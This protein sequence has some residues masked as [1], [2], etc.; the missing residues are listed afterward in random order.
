MHFAQNLPGREKHVDNVCLKSRQGIC[1]VVLEARGNKWNFKVDTK[2][3]TAYRIQLQSQAS[4]YTPFKI[5]TAC[6]MLFI[7]FPR[8]E[9]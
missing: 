9:K 3:Q 1:P 2:F 6:H 4:S 7:Q 5:E 8:A